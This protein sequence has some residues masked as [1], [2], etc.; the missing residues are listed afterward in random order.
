MQSIQNP[1]KEPINQKAPDD[2]SS[3]IAEIKKAL[4]C[5]RSGQLPAAGF[6][7]QKLLG[8]VPEHAEAMYLLAM[9]AFDAGHLAESI[10]CLGTAL[11]I[12]PANPVFWAGLGELFVAQNRYQDAISCYEKAV[13][14]KPDYVEAYYDMGNSLYH[15]KDLGAAVY[16]YQKAL[17]LK[18]QLVEAYFNIANIYMD[19]RNYEK[20]ISLFRQALMIKP[21]YVE[22]CFNMAIAYAELGRPQDA[23]ASYQQAIGIKPNMGTAHFN[24]GILYQEQ[25][26]FDL[27]IESY[28]NALKCRP[29]FTEAYNNL[30]LVYHE[31]GRMQEAM[32]WYRKALEK[33]HGHAAAHYNLGKAFHDL[34]QHDDAIGLYQKAIN[35]KPDYYRAYNN[36][37]RAWQDLLQI[38]RAIDGYQKAIAIKPDYAEAH[39]NLSTALLLTGDFANGGREYEWR[40]KRH[41]WTN[42]YPHRFAQPRWQGEC[43]DGKRLLIHS[44][45][46]FGDVLQFIRYLP[47]V[48]RFGS[49]GTIIFETRKSL[50]SLI[51]NFPGIDEII[52]MHHD[53]G[54]ATAFDLYAP[55]LAL[56]A[57]FQTRLETIPDTVPY[58]H[59][60]PRKIDE[61]KSRLPHKGL[62]VGLVWAGTAVDPNRS[63]PLDKFAM[64][65]TMPDLHLVGLQK[66]PEAE[67][68]KL[69]GLPQNLQV[70]N[71]GEELEDFADTAAVI[72]NLDLIISIDTSVAHLA[73]AMGKPTWLLLPFSPDWRWLLNRED[74]PWYPTMRLFRQPSPGNWKSVG[75]QI[76]SELRH[77]VAERQMTH[78]GD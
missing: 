46:G 51:K 16:N 11:N 69:E 7:Y 5:Y 29:D 26:Q 62:K 30:G 23:M 36:M 60:D 18:P 1:L 73:G 32:K 28:Q 37:A 31:Q 19:Q 76:A 68:L 66:G 48:K 42:T 52:E 35:L 71:V 72:H 6:I 34:A 78:L 21:Q 3:L 74:S 54:P 39:F 20:A 49:A 59:A 41:G 14:L 40:F 13:A 10:D 43:F 64:L 61:W 65:A 47:M 77:G 4:N 25:K 56:P 50:I 63:C 44:E 58:I 22:A 55:L 8:R 9:L 15:L 27:A 38:D 45:Q 2:R 24:L 67:R 17:Q 33:N 12:D 57:I 75:Q 53:K 70:E